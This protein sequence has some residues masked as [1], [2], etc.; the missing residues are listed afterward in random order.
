MSSDLVDNILQ[1]EKEKEEKALQSTQVN[2]EVPVNFD[3]GHLALYDTNLI[4][5][6]KYRNNVNSYL[7]KLTRDNAQLFMNELWQRETMKVDGYVV[8]KLPKPILRLPRAKPVPKPKMPT[9]W[10]AFAARKGIQKRKKDKLVYDEATNEWRPRYGYR[11]I[12]NQSGDDWVVE[13]KEGKDPEE[14]LNASREAKKERVAKNE[15]QR[16]RNIAKTKGVKIANNQDSVAPEEA[17]LPGEKPSLNSLTKAASLAKVST[18]SIGKFQEQ[19]SNEK[20]VKGVGGKKRKFEPNEANVG[21]E[22]NKNL[23]LAEEILSAKPKLNVKKAVTN[24]ELT[25]QTAQA[26]ANSENGGRR[27]KPVKGKKGRNS[28]RGHFDKQKHKFTGKKGS[29]GSG[30]GG[31]RGGGGGN[32]KGGASK[33]PFKGPSKGQSKG[34]FKGGK[35]GGNAKAGKSKGK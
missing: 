26:Q 21:E 2:K 9:K 23:K 7:A 29:S 19:A 1:S 12:K 13:D 33:G 18:A 14:L 34:P 15:Y 35:K 27:K 10:E 28:S 31:G 20:P 16:L 24:Q 11:S 32:R 4:D 17:V 25:T 6:K 8:A 5:E 30:G 3:L 22:K